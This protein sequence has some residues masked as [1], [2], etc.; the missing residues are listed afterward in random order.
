ME[1]QPLNVGQLLSTDKRRL[2]L[3]NAVLEDLESEAEFK[4]VLAYIAQSKGID[5][6]ELEGADFD[7]L[8]A[9]RRLGYRLQ[10]KLLEPLD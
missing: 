3:L 9:V 10:A 2:A 8:S 5:L 6:P 4:S 1:F 7:F